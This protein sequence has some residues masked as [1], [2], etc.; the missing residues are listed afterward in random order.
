MRINGSEWTDISRVDSLNI[1]R[2]IEITKKY[3]WQDEGW[4]ILWHQR[5]TY[6]K[7]TANLWLIFESIR[8]ISNWRY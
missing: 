3:G 5:D 7:E 2:L 8:P 1:T 6:G 4:L